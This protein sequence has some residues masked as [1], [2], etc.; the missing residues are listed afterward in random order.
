[1]GRKGKPK[2][3]QIERIQGAE[4][5]LINLS[6]TELLLVPFTLGKAGLVN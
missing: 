3:N 1:M 5:S 2:V 6:L 4:P